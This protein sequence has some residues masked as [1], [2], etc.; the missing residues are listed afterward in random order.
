[1]K[2]KQPT[3]SAAK[4]DYWKHIIREWEGSGCVTQASFCRQAGISIKSFSRWRSVFAREA[5]QSQSGVGFAKVEVQAPHSA[6]SGVRIALSP[7]AHIDISPD[8]DEATLRRV[9]SVCV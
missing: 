1:M 9:L 8:F 6:G 2:S 5:L 3:R 4:R 7:H